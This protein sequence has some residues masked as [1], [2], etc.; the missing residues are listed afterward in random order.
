VTLL[1]P[2]R[3][4]AETPGTAPAKAE[5]AE[6][7]PAAPTRVERLEEERRQ[8][9]SRLLKPAKPG[10]L[11]RQILA[12]E[13]QER[14]A[15]L[16]F[17]YKGFYPRFQSISSG[18]RTAPAIRFWEP[19]V[20]GGPVSVH[21]SA[22]YSLAGYQLY[23]AQVGL[24]PY[25]EG[26]LPARSTRGDDVH[27]LGALTRSRASHLILYGSARYRHNPRERFFG[28]GPDSRLEDRSLYLLQDDLYEI[29]GGYQFSERVTAT[30][31]AG[32]LQVDAGRSDDEALPSV[33]DLF[34]AGSAPGLGAQPDYVRVQGTFLVDG[35][36]RPGNPHRGGLLALSLARYDDRD[37]DAHGFNRL[38]IDARGYLSLGS[39][40]RVLAA[41][42]LTSIDSTEAGARVPFYLMDA[43]SNSHTLRGFQSLRF[44]DQRLLSLQ[45]E[46]R[47][48]AAPA[49]E[50]ALFCDAGKAFP[51]GFSLDDLETGYGVGLRV[52]TLDA[53]LFRV[54]VARSRE[55]TRVYLRFGAAF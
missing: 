12:I 21:A 36:D 34:D 19:R 33:A 38:A 35:R 25:V 18:S 17:H 48:E 51:D 44:R 42:V 50:L 53:T 55:G 10:F 27:E 1:V 31:R 37:G 29:V 2:G 24:I 46:Y 9:A 52:K 30:V 13:K 41:R 6:A 22:A 32:L 26:K 40:Q 47:W 20:G 28:V 43:L 39:P 7:E 23:D 3:V 14:P 49:L 45:A 16:D 15:I 4:A 5:S 8:R 54:D 11:E